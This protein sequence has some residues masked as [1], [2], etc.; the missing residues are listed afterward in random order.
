MSIIDDEKSQ[1]IWLNAIDVNAAPLAHSGQGS[2]LMLFLPPYTRT[3]KPTPSVL[4]RMK[5]IIFMGHLNAEH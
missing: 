4:S 3:R 5:K 1:Q 2:N